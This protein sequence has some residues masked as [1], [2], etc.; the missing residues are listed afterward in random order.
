MY[1]DDCKKSKESFCGERSTVKD[2]WVE[3]KD[4]GRVSFIGLEVDGQVSM[5]CDEGIVSL[6]LN[7]ITI[8]KL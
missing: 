7:E 5:K 6:H 1:L 3:L 8:G 2:K 4:Y